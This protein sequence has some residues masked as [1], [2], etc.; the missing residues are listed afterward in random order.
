M[1]SKKR[2]W[3]ALLV[4]LVGAVATTLLLQKNEAGNFEISLKTGK[5]TNRFAKLL[6][7]EGEGTA[8]TNLTEEI[9]EKYGTEILKANQSGSKTE[10]VYLPNDS[11]LDDILK[12][13][14]TKGFSFEKI[15]TQKDFQ[16]TGENTAEVV[17]KYLQEIAVT[18]DDNSSGKEFLLSIAELVA[19][20]K[21]ENLRNYIAGNR[22]QIADLLT[23]R[24]PSRWLGFHV[25]LTNVLNQQAEL[26][27]AILKMEEDPLFATLAIQQIEEVSQKEAGLL[28]MVKNNLV[29]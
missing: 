27:D 12:Q 15:F 23:V 5:E 29:N 20:N 10:G 22:G 1:A 11:F 17:K 14:T 13:E 19:D 21:P 28:T 18:Y 24:V 2:I 16:T 7:L 3:T 25:E 4:L 6:G 8:E 26:G 9:F